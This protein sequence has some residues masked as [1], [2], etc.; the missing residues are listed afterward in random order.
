[1]SSI[2]MEDSVN[3]IVFVA[4]D[5]ETT[6]FNPNSDRI[7]EVGAVKFKD[8]KELDRF[9]ELVNPGMS[10]PQHSVEIS[11]IDDAMVSDAPD[12]TA[13]LKRFIL[14]IRD[15]VLIA[16]NAN[17]DT[18]F[19]RAAASSDAE[20]NITNIIIDTLKLARRA[21]PKQQ[22]YSLQNL[23]KALGL[24]SNAAH[25]ALDDSLQCMNIFLA[26]AQELSVMGH[27]SLKDVL[28]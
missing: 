5:F 8:R 18:S 7:I 6:G 11:G 21:Y 16:H 15:S 25:R 28:D 20:L 2:N 13:V 9:N 23:V 4:F 27:I 12:I 26:C 19:L 10:I 17:F 24:R 14:F 22:S 3:D 1:M